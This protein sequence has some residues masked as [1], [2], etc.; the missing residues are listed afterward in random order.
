MPPTDLRIL[1]PLEK[2]GSE[3]GLVRFA[4]TLA[5]TRKGELHLTH[6]LTESASQE[7]AGQLLKQMKRVHP[8][9]E[10][11][12]IPHLVEASTVTDG[13]KAAV[14]RWKC[15]M[16]VMGWYHEVE[17]VA[18]L[19]AR[20]RALAK[21]I[22][23]DTLIFKDRNFRPA[24]RVLVPTG[25]G[26]HAL[27]GLQ[28]GYELARAW[29]AEIEV[30]R[31]ARAPGYSSGDP[32]LQRYCRQLRHDTE[33]QL[34]LLGIDVP[35]TVLPARDILSPIVQA[36][37]ADDLVVL[38]ASNDWRQEEH[39]AGSIP[40]EIANRVPGSVLMVRSSIPNKAL[41]SQ[42]FWANTIRLDLRAEDKWDA[43]TQLVNALV[44]ERQVPAS[45]RQAV[46]DAAVQ[47]ERKTSTAMG[48][49]IAIP[50]APIPDLPGIIGCLGICPQGIDFG[51]SQPT[52]VRFI[53][54]ILTPQQ[55]YRSYIPVLAQIAT[56]MRSDRT[57][58]AFLHCQTP[59]EV[60]ALIRGQEESRGNALRR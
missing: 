34:D 41:L 55:N 60:T 47:R 45:Q 10:V 36:A 19:A 38:G 44:E 51:E 14:D 52:P 57:R 4:A 50:H 15:N 24:R 48:H 11:H 18:I 17:K 42:I 7:H 16:M 56:I 40:D 32:I 8:G 13:I 1:V 27:M 39:L 22:R 12:A 35:V 3:E 6:I 29:K 30:M 20:N 9:Q 54:L 25:G 26:S 37:R 43:I 28:I 49:E 2:P 59:S 33:L 5:L 23:L 58:Q 31:I 46:L 21:E 53:F